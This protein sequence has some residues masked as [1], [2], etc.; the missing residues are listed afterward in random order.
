[1]VSYKLKQVANSRQKL[2][3]NNIQASDI[4][5]I[6]SEVLKQI[7]GGNAPTPA[8]WAAMLAYKNTPPSRDLAGAIAEGM[9][10]EIQIG[11]VE[12]S[13]TTVN[14]KIL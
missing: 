4:V 10:I 12:A 11:V 1:M 5:Q 8:E 7:S 9:D 2:N 6:D 13:H 14:Q 3:L